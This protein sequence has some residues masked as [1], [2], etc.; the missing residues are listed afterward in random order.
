MNERNYYVSLISTNL[1]ICVY[2]SSG[3]KREVYARW[4]YLFQC[5]LIHD[6]ILIVQ[7]RFFAARPW[8]GISG[9]IGRGH[10]IFPVTAKD[11]RPY[12]E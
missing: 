3:L 6:V 12:F 8:I 4:D 10:E 9:N 2:V 1:L 5:H 7:R 11:R